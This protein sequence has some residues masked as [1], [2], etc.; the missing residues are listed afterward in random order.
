MGKAPY[1]V[2]YW[3]NG[4]LH[5]GA[6]FDND[7]VSSGKRWQLA[8]GSRPRARRRLVHPTACCSPSF[9]P[10]LI[11]CA[12]PLWVDLTIHST[13][14]RT[15]VPCCVSGVRDRWDAG[16]AEKVRKRQ[17]K[18]SIDSCSAFQWPACVEIPSAVA[19]RRSRET[20]HGLVRPFAP[21][22]ITPPL[23]HQRHDLD[24]VLPPESNVWLIIKA[25]LGHVPLPSMAVP[26]PEPASGSLGHTGILK[27]WTRCFHV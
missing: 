3:Q 2:A 11:S 5:L 24:L 21:M 1:P 27:S 26:Q 22:G 15:R 16:Q 18:T 8:A 12:G 13:A 6:A 4:G 20:L 9:P 23:A 25:I 17:R 10:V 19:H 7:G 14:C